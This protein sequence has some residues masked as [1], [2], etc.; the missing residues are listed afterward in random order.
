VSGLF[1]IS[2]IHAIANRPHTHETCY[3]NVAAK[4]SRYLVVQ[5]TE[6]A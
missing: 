2:P 5:P 4:E 3:P 6:I 1:S